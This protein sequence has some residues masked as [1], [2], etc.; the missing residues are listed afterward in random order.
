MGHTLMP[1]RSFRLLLWSLALF[2][3]L[4]DQASKYSV[5]AWLAKVDD[6]TFVLLRPTA[7]KGFQLRTQYQTDPKAGPVVP[8]VNQGA[9]FGFLNDPKYGNSANAGFALISFLAALAIAYW[10]SFRATA[11]DGWLCA[12]L[13]LILGGTLGN[14]YDRV[15]FGGVRDF[16][17]WNYLYD[18][19]VFNFADCCL[20]CGAGLLL[21]QAFGANRHPLPIAPRINPGLA[22][23][24]Q[25]PSPMVVL[26]HRV[27][28]ELGS[29]DDRYPHP[30]LRY[31]SVH[32]E[33]RT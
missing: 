10:S 14:L 1:E 21:L 15:V 27:L 22:R 3:V 26:S 16:L 23:L 6:H 32:V 12:A 8:Y 4:A 20:V 31:R 25:Y 24:L 28:H 33:R 13:G 30:V 29:A 2:G 18:W 9:L 11:R 7:D 5:F 19:P 17:H